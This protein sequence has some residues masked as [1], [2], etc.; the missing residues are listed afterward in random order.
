MEKTTDGAYAIIP[1]NG[2][3]LVYKDANDDYQPIAA[4]ETGTGYAQVPMSSLNMG[5]NVSADGKTIKVYTAWEVDPSSATTWKGYKEHKAGGNSETT[6]AGGNVKFY[7]RDGETIY[8]EA[9]N[10]NVLLGEKGADAELG[11]RK[12]D[13][14]SLAANTTKGLWAYP[15]K[16][17]LD[18]NSF[19]AVITFGTTG[20]AVTIPASLKAGET[21]TGLLITADGTGSTPIITL[22]NKANVEVTTDLFEAT[23]DKSMEGG[24]FTFAY[25]KNK[26]ETGVELTVTPAE[27]L[28]MPAAAEDDTGKLYIL[29]NGVPVTVTVK[30]TAR[31]DAETIAAV[32]A[33]I[34]KAA[35]KA[36]DANFTAN[37]ANTAKTAAI[38]LLSNLVGNSKPY[39]N[40]LDMATGTD[41]YD[42]TQIRAVVNGTKENPE[43]TEG[44]YSLTVY[45]KSNDV[46]DSITLTIKGAAKTWAEVQ[47]KNAN[48]AIAAA[49]AEIEKIKSLTTDEDPSEDG[50]KT[51]LLAAVSEALATLNEAD[52]A[53]AQVKGEVTEFTFAKNKVNAKIV[54][55][56]EGGEAVTVELSEVGVTKK[57]G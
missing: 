57:A 16:K 30:T 31:T 2:M 51:A 19:E 37:D 38:A 4:T 3:K 43:G 32:K 6:P 12:T 42:F 39:E 47:E 1:L 26:S 20:Y 46:K 5:D 33:D 13:P 41:G 9:A 18:A 45:L 44:L 56:S 7:V 40:N 24:K 50:A 52:D 8:V 21:S 29:V 53:V 28:N 55:T 25:A 48:E 36:I 27:A 23:A 35:A 54:L 49:K 34:E 14:G 10:A 11:N 15:V 17:N 22:K